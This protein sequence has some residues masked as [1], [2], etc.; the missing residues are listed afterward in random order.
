MQKAVAIV[1]ITVL[2]REKLA[3]SI[4]EGIIKFHMKEYTYWNVEGSEMNER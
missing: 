1:N 2:R 3:Y 4:W